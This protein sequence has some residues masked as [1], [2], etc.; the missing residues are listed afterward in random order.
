MLTSCKVL[1]NNYWIK[2]TINSFNYKN[3]MIFLELNKL[4][5]LSTAEIDFSNIPISLHG[6]GNST[7][8]VEYLSN[9]T[10]NNI[11]ISQFLNYFTS[12]IHKFRYLSGER[13][14]LNFSE[15]DQW[16]NMN[17]VIEPPQPIFENN[18]VVNNYIDIDYFE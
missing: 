13:L 17:I 7:N 2:F 10:D 5:F 11:L 9:N 18:Y 12:E 1:Y 15:N 3:I 4:L 6:N 16:Q 8:L 14:I